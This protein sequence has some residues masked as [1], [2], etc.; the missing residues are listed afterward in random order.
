MSS[1]YARIAFAEHAVQLR[2][3]RGRGR[4]GA[5]RVL[6]VERGAGRRGDGVSD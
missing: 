6:G 4:V 3:R 1:Q 5:P 2:A